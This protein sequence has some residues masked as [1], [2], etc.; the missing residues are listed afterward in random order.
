MWLVSP[1]GA[2]GTGG[3]DVGV[4]LD[5][6][7]WE[8]KSRWEKDSFTR[9]LAPKGLFQGK[10]PGVQH[11]VLS[12]LLSTFTEM[13]QKRFEIF[14]QAVFMYP[15]CLYWTSYSAC[16]SCAHLCPV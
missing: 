14:E 12:K 13:L 15:W 4:G 10:R 3:S 11:F 8:V 2:R 7:E 5:D 6:R 16:G 1:S 9:I